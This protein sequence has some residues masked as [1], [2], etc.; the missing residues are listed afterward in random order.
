VNLRLGNECG[1]FCD[2][3]S[4]FQSLQHERSSE[5]GFFSP[6]EYS[7]D[8]LIYFRHYFMRKKDLRG[9]QNLEGLISDKIPINFQINN[10]KMVVKDI[11]AKKE[12]P[13]VIS[14]SHIHPAKN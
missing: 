12:F 1:L 4:T 7:P 2:L 11:R 10:L 13:S 9:F 5:K 14:P 3:V 6:C 8:P